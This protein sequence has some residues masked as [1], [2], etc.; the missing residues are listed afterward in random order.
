MRGR[1]RAVYH[2][3]HARPLE[4]RRGDHAIHKRRRPTATLILL[5]RHGRTPTTGTILPGRAP[6]LHLAE[7][8]RKE[9]EAAAERIARLKA[10]AAVYS[11]PLERARET[12]EPIAQRRGL[13]IRI[14]PGL[15][16]CEIG[17]WTGIELAQGG[18]AARSGQ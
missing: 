12:A 13:E 16:E 10:V 6:G 3:A 5:V 15:I 11:S 1:R 14:E 17:E 2:S 9:A 8:G 18:Q 4:R 7:E